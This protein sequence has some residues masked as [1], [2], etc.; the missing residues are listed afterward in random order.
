M[1]SAAVNSPLSQ[2][3]EVSLTSVIV[4]ESRRWSGRVE[5]GSVD[6]KEERVSGSV[7]L[8]S[9]GFSH[10]VLKGLLWTLFDRKDT[11]RTFSSEQR[12]II[13]HSDENKKCVRCHKFLT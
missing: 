13:W 11:N 1:W 6:E 10:C 2:I 3:P 5:Q 9:R 7:A 8:S 4:R 12:R